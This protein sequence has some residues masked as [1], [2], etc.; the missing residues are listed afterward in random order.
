MSLKDLGAF[1]DVNTSGLKP[2]LCNT[3]IVSNGAL[4]YTQLATLNNLQSRFE[5]IHLCTLKFC[6]N[7]SD[8]A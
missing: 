7:R 3:S 4:S 2:P 6:T 5:A 1:I 8:E